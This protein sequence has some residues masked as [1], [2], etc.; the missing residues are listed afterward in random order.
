[1]GSTRPPGRLAHPITTDV[2]TVPTSTTELLD[3]AMD[4]SNFT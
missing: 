3:G 1:M 4:K 2:Y